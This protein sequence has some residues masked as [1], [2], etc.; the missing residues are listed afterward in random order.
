MSLL[1]EAEVSALL[2]VLL[3]IGCIPFYSGLMLLWVGFDVSQ[4]LFALY[5]FVIYNMYLLS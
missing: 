3:S 5:F 4:L 1:N 2:V